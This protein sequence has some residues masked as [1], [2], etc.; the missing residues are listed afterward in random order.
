MSCQGGCNIPYGG[1]EHVVRENYEILW[2]SFYSQFFLAIAYHGTTGAGDSRL[3][4]LRPHG[5]P[6]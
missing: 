1:Q 3:A 4:T 2:V 6:S 5:R